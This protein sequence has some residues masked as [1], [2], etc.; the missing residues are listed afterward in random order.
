MGSV[1]EWIV[2]TISLTSLNSP[3]LFPN[4]DKRFTEAIQFFERLSLWLMDASLYPS[5]HYLRT[6]PRRVIHLFTAMQLA[7][8]VILWVVKVSALAI[9]FPL[10]I[11]LGVP[12]RMLAGR[13]FKAEYLAAL[14]AEEEPEDEETQWH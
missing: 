2:F 12:L 11:A 6:V 14:D 8:L 4:S 13:I 1:L 5:T 3:N 7:G 9:L 10:F